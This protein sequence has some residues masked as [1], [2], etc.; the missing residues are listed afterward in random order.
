MYLLHNKKS[1]K[2]LV[3]KLSPYTQNPDKD[4]YLYLDRFD[5]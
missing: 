5:R 3:E 1:L 4:S 2:Y